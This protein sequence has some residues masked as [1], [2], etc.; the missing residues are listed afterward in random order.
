MSLEESKI[1]GQRQWSLEVNGRRQCTL[2]NDYLGQKNEKKKKKK[3]AKPT[4][5]LT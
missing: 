1:E 3:K 4:M 5:L 2:L